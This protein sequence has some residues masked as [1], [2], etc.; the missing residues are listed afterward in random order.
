MINHLKEGFTF[1]T[2]EY[3]TVGD[4]VILVESKIE[5]LGSYVDS[6]F[7][8]DESVMLK[9]DTQ[10]V[11][12]VFDKQ[13][14]APLCSLL[15]NYSKNSEISLVVC[16]TTGGRGEVFHDEGEDLGVTFLFHSNE[17]NHLGRPHVHVIDR[18]TFEEIS[19]DLKTIKELKHSS[20]KES[21]KFSEKKLKKVQK[22]IR[23]HLIDFQ[24]YWNET[25]NGFKIEVDI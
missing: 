1:K 2:E 6:P 4:F 20:T 9:T 13:S 24:N 10:N 14:K 16:L 22:F 3:E 15:D 18:N 8:G 12:Y 17:G 21:S 11:R 25:T 5:P 7:P 23:S 19:I